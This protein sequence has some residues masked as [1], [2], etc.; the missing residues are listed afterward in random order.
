MS[1]NW[2]LNFIHFWNV[3]CNYNF[4]FELVLK[5]KRL[6]FKFCYNEL[7]VC[8]DRKEWLLQRYL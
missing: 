5:S 2:I 6:K 4:E 3:L 7:N 8:T 1:I